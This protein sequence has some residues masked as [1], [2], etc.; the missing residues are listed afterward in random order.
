MLRIL[1][2][3]SSI[4]VQKVVW[5]CDE[6][7]LKYERVDVGGKFGGN[8]TPEYLAKNP[9]GLVPTLEED[10]FILPESDAIVRYIAAKHSAGNLW[11]DDP[12]ERAQADRWMVWASTSFIAAM[13]DA[14]WELIRVAPEKRDAA[15]VEASRAKGEKCE[16][17]LD[18]QLATRRFLTGE[19][20]TA[21]D[22]VVGTAVHRWLHLPLERTPRPNLER[23]YRELESRPGSRQVT[24]Q[25]LT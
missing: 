10:G 3:L 22:I 21:A 25:A 7:S 13:R 6:L 9:T 12:R 19:R 2:R 15:K 23:Y 20:F 11:P 1:G 17:T 5:C 4:N 14:F 18:A 24:S 8:D 16:A